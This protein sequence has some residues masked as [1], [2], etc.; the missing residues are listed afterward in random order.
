MFEGLR[1]RIEQLLAQHTAP[2]DARASIDLLHS[3]VLDAKVSVS[4][5][6]DGVVATER[7]LVM[8]Q[9]QLGDA[10]RRGR[11]AAEIPDQD[12]V[13]LAERYSAKHRER[14]A[15]L[16]RK[17]AVQRDELALA[18]REVGE[19]TAQLRAA[20]QGLGAGAASAGAAWRDIESAGGVR[21][22]TDMQGDLLRS[23]LDR[24]AHEAA[25]DAQLAHLKRK[26]GKDSPTDR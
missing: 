26:L 19:M 9:K 6:R 1:G 20:R 25:A 12:T 16:E 3:A 13:D 8:E 11:L 14:A 17:L 10:E 23:N 4:A 5:M 7:E 18:E 24:A 15:V 21:P 22:E 2:A